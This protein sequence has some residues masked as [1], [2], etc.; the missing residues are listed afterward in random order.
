MARQSQQGRCVSEMNTA[1]LAL[2][3][4]PQGAK[5]APGV[6]PCPAVP[7]VLSPDLRR[8]A[9]SH[10]GTIFFRP[11]FF[12]LVDSFLLSPFVPFWGPSG[13]AEPSVLGASE[14]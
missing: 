10:Q 8:A 1:L 7:L 4:W 13:V 5:K 12:L 14:L 9:K 11:F 3:E 2:A 6:R